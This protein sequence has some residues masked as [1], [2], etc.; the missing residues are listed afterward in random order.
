MGTRKDSKQTI[1]FSAWIEKLKSFG[2]TTS[3]RGGNRVLIGKNGCGAVLDKAASGEPQFAVRPGISMGE[4]IAHLLDRGFQKFWQ[5]GDRTFP[6]AADQLTALHQFEQ[7]L[8]ALMGLTGLYNQALG[9]VSSRYVYD[10]VEGREGPRVH[11]T[12]D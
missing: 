7:D 12:F 6:A 1:D 4:N 5:S 2:F 3:D 11:H 8:R 10:R 9:T